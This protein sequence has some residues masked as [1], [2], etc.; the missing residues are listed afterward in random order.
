MQFGFGGGDGSCRLFLLF[1]P[2][3][4]GRGAGAKPRCPGNVGLGKVLTSADGE[5]IFGFD[6]NQSG[7]DGV[8]AT[9]AN[10]ETFNQNDGKIK[11]SFGKNLAPERLRR[12]RHRGRRRGAYRG[13]E[14]AQGKLFPHRY[15]KVMDP[16]GAGKFTGEWTPPLKGLISEQM[17]NDQT[18]QTSLLF[19]LT[20]LKSGE[21]P[22]LLVSDVATN[23]F[24]NVIS[25]DPDLLCLC[26]GPQ[27]GL[28][29]AANK[30]IFAL[31]PDSGAVGGEPRSTCSSI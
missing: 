3:R 14:G 17:A 9:A 28:Y 13:R 24:S 12:R 15:Y 11:K 1:L 30:A 16:V 27:L 10:V 22:M 25:L 26:D 31:S 8:L 5:Q 20:N 4:G 2:N 21:A 6:I 29:T 7:D 18:T 23:T 19:A